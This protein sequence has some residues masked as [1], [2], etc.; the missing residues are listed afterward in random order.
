MADWFVGGSR[1]LTDS[2]YVAVPEE[3]RAAGFISKFGFRTVSS[4][5]ISLRVN[6]VQLVRGVL[7]VDTVTQIR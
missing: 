7:K 4:G 2:V 3:S 1:R 5:S 6:L